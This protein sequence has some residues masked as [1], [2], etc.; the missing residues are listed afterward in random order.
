[1]TA[2]PSAGGSLPA[3][4]IRHSVVPAEPHTVQP[5]EQRRWLMGPGLDL[6]TIVNATWPLWVGV[7]LLSDGFAGTA[8]IRFWQVYFITMPHRWITLPAVWLDR[9]RLRHHP[10]AFLVIAAIVTAVCCGVRFTTGQVTCLLTIDY[11]WNAWHFAAQ[12]HG[13]YRIYDRLAD[14]DRRAG[15]T[16]EKFAFRGFLLYITLRVAGGTWSQ[17]VLDEWLTRGDWAAATIPFM[18]LA[19]LLLLRRNRS[20]GRFSYLLSVSVLYLC[21]LAAVHWPNPRMVLILTT[22]SA[23][24]HAME[25]LALVGWMVQQRHHQHGNALGPLSWLAPRWIAVLTVFV[26]LLGTTGWWLESEPSQTW[27]LINVIV[28]FLH[29]AYDGMIWRRPRKRR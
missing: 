12:H 24:F 3:D 27:L 10:V 23:L 21:L 7:M 19:N 9:E 28:A 1:M 15:V 29:Y 13:V 14:P 8:G 18:M 25:Y 20:V 22:A 6:L 4:I 16:W 2:G 11:V 5:W 26:I 17:P